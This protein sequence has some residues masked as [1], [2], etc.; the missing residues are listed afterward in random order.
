LASEWHIVFYIA[1]AI[2]LIGGAFYGICASGERQTWCP[3]PAAVKEDAAN[4]E[5]GELTVKNAVQEP[6]P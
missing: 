3:A 6:V 4:I 5:I 1:A 2:Y